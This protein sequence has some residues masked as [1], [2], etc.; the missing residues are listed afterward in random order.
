[1]IVWEDADILVCHKPPGL[2]VQTARVGGTDMES[3]LKNRRAARGEDAY[4]GIVHRLDQ[5]VEGLLVFA[6][7]KEAASFL[8][9]ELQGD[10]F[11]KRYYAVTEGRRLPPEAVLEDDMAKDA[12]NRRA[13]I[14]PRASAGAKHAKLRYRV[15]AETEDRQL[16]EIVLET[17][18]FHQIRLQ[19][20]H[21]GS[22][23]AGDK[24]YGGSPSD[25]P[26][27]LCACELS[28]RHPRTGEEMRFRIRPRGE[29]FLLFSER[30]EELFPV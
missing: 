9:R 12:K 2:A 24:K 29:G 26:L 5:P 17:G 30:E 27:C 6:K 25:V 1:M 11:T 16:V 14:L 15:L 3:L 21:R 23:I 20:S 13:V 8:S 22:P 7:T 19:F 18:R 10:R 4:L 28:F